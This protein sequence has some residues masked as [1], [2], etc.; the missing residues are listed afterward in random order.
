MINTF[1]K[2]INSYI[3][4]TVI[5]N[6]QYI[7][8]EIVDT[9]EKENSFELKFIDDGEKMQWKEL[10]YSKDEK[11]IEVRN[12]Y[13][14]NPLI[15]KFNNEGL[16]S[17]DGKPFVNESEVNI[18]LGC[19]DTF[20]LG[21]QVENTFFY[22]LSQNF[23]G[24]YWNVGLPGSG[25]E[26]QFRV[27]YY[28]VKKYNVR[29]KNLFHWLPFRNRHEFLIKKYNDKLPHFTTVLP[30][31]DDY[32]FKQLPFEMT[33][34]FTSDS[35]I[36]MKYISYTSAINKIVTDRGGRYLVLNYDVVWNT[37]SLD[38]KCH[39]LYDISKSHIM[40]RDLGHPDYNSH[41]NIF[42]AFMNADKIKDISFSEVGNFK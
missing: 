1:H 37:P 20:G 3:D 19:S 22:K 6:Y 23:D 9:V 29:I 14:K 28:L 8:K 33:R 30:R 10:K 40:A 17:I 16:R 24:D 27:L 13:I 12:H 2:H 39:E 11:E 34:Y 41:H 31:E 26:T 35:S 18:F 36:A 21:M 32:Y 5:S 4:E 25:V 42:S 38:V 15:Y 7:Q